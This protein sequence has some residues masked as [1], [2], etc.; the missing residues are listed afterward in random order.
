MKNKLF[1][2]CLFTLLNSYCFAQCIDVDLTFG[3][4]GFI[5]NNATS[6]T[7]MPFYTAIPTADNKIL[8]TDS[9]TVSRFND[10][11]S[12][13][14]SFG[15]NGTVTFTNYFFINKIIVV[16]TDCYV[17]GYQ[18]G[19]FT[20]NPTTYTNIKIA[21]IDTNGNV[22]S[23]PP[24]DFGENEYGIDIALTSD[25]KLMAAC[26]KW[27]GGWEKLFLLKL[28]LDGTVDTTFQNNGT[29][30]IYL[31]PQ[32]T[33]VERI[34]N[35]DNK[36][37]IVCTGYFGSNRDIGLVKMDENGNLDTTFNGTGTAFFD[38]GS[39]ERVWEVKLK[40]NIVYA[41]LNDGDNINNRIASY[42]L[43]TL[44]LQTPIHLNYSVN[45]YGEKFIVN[46][47][48][49]IMTVAISDS[50]LS[51]NKDSILIKYLPNG[52]LDTS[53]CSGGI[54]PFNISYANN[55]IVDDQKNY[56]FR[57]GTD[58][59]LITG[60]YSI[61]YSGGASPAPQYVACVRFVP[62]NLAT[63]NFKDNK[64]ILSP[65]PSDSNLTLKLKNNIGGNVTMQIFNSLGQLIKQDIIDMAANSVTIS[66]ADLATDFYLIKIQDAEGNYYNSK[67]LKK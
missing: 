10:N 33:H 59:I 36:L 2:T 45:F 12:I 19:Q 54:Q 35:Y 24:F 66:V 40:N 65:N 64:L 47:D 7:P 18:D 9:Q 8:S 34:F 28:N 51:C 13:D 49:R 67:F 55:Y 56:I 6:T 16:G 11:G 44:T 21:K 3:N 43:N 25:N 63:T 4:D 26:W 42:N 50:C 53:F 37:L 20:G 39:L 52:T 46:D 38:N 58:K 48:N 29:K 57:I 17:I 32:K 30:E 31:F 62:G 22:T 61:P 41:R 14:T 5:S 1:L 23:F 60:T 15:I 27:G